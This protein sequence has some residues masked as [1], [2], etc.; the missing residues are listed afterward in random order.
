WRSSGRKPGT[1]EG[2]R[3]PRAEALNGIAAGAGQCGGSSLRV[4]PEKG[5]EVLI[6]SLSFGP[7]I[8]FRAG[9]GTDR[10]RVETFR[11][12]AFWTDPGSITSLRDSGFQVAAIVPGI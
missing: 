12:P 10:P 6:Y 3:G 2:S 8:G 7:G 9:A 5:L 4:P 1:R 11:A